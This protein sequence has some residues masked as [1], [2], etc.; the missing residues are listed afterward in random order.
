MRR[1][2][3]K[4]EEKA[5]ELEVENSALN[6]TREEAVVGQISTQEE[7]NFCKLDAFK[8]NIIDDFKSSTEYHEEI[9]CEARS[10]FDKG[11]IHIILQLH[12]YF[13]DE[14]I[15]LRTY[16]SNFDNDVCRRGADFVPFTSE[17]MDAL[18]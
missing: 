6:T 17:E 10:F 13:K 8:K 12:Q 18:R 16:S 14:F 4:E 2:T 3:Y 15:L 7:L 11:C 9:D 5:A 1:S